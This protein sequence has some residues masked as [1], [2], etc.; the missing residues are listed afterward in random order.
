MKRTILVTDTLFIFKEHE[1]ILKSAGFEVKRLTNPQATEEEL[2]KAVKDVDGYILGGIEKLTN[3][4]IEETNKLKAIIFT[5]TDWAK[6]IPGHETATKKGIAIA[7]C[8]G[9]N[10]QSVAEYTITLILLMLRRVLELGNTG[11]ETFITT[12]SLSEINIGIVGLGRIGKLVTKMLKSLG[13]VN[14][15]YWNRTR[16]LPIEKEIGI[17]YLPLPDL[18]KTCDVITN[19]LSSQAEQLLTSEL[20]NNSKDG[21]ILINTGGHI[22]YD[23]NSLYNLLYSKKAR[24]AFDIN[25]SDK[26]FDNLPHNLWFRSNEMTAYNTLS[27]NKLVSDMAINSIIN[28]LTTGKDEHLVNPEY[29]KYKK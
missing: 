26:R 17:K 2:I 24:A 3:E 8:P 29:I 20:L 16:K 28:L 15:F 5:G 12:K 7:N 4:V 10:S 6:Y 14:L 1:N 22:P 27:A 18:F 23:L 13:A 9:A 11:K 19:H 21:V 25:P